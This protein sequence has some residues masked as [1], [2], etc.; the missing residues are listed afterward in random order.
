MDSDW[1]GNGKCLV[2]RILAHVKNLQSEGGKVCNAGNVDA[3]EHEN[4][5]KT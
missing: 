1:D 5:T 3:E 4:K 2:I